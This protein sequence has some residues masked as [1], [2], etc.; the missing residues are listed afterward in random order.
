MSL[1]YK[2]IVKHYNWTLCIKHDHTVS[3]R[4]DNPSLTSRWAVAS[5]SRDGP[6]PS[7][8]LVY[9]GFTAR[10]TLP[11]FTDRVHG[12]LS[13]LPVNTGREHG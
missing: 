1:I 6:L 7:D 11:V 13:T 8:G 4:V 5:A 2:D 9:H 10:Y 3:L 12:R